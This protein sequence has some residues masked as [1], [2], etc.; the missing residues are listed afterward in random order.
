MVRRRL[1]VRPRAAVRYCSDNTVAG[2]ATPL[3]NIQPN[4]ARNALRE[5]PHVLHLVPPRK[6][7]PPDLRA[8]L[9]EVLQ[10][11]PVARRVAEPDALEGLERPAALCVARA[12]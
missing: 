12:H 2:R 4:Q 8:E 11:H 3:A 10:E 7:E 5:P 1:G 6:L 9:P